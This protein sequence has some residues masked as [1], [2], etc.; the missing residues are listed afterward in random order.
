MTTKADTFLARLDRDYLEKYSALLYV[1]PLPWSVLSLAA[2][3]AAT[4]VLSLAG[5]AADT[6]CANLRTFLGG[7]AVLAYTVLLLYAMLVIG[8]DWARLGRVGVFGVEVVMGILAFV[9]YCCGTLWLKDQGGISSSSSSSSSGSSAAVCSDAVRY[10]SLVLIVGYWIVLGGAAIWLLVHRVSVALARR[11]DV[12]VA[13]TK[14]VTASD[15]VAVA[16][17][18]HDGEA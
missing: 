10:T 14:A 6:D 12:P 3:L 18:S 16:Q 7:A 4:L 1:A 17:S 11:R 5:S 9:W 13:A 2:A 8:P 15:A